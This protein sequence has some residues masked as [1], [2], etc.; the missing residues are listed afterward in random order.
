MEPIKG[1]L[2]H[3]WKF[4]LII[5]E[6]YNLFKKGLINVYFPLYSVVEYD[7]K[8][9]VIIW[10]LLIKQDLF[11]IIGPKIHAT[12]IHLIEGLNKRGEFQPS[13][14]APL[15]TFLTTV[16]VVIEKVCGQLF[17]FLPKCLIILELFKLRNPPAKLRKVW[18]VNSFWS[19]KV[20]I[21][22][23]KSVH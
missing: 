13:L 18:K 7:N 22:F 8:I 20:F 21:F 12:L 17:Q 14:H 15:I 6:G 1:K 5:F 23:G 2:L 19:Q 10:R 3:I 4:E 9:I 16:D 11:E